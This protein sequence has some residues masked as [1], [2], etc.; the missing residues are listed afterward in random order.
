MP[1]TRDAHVTSK[2]NTMNHALIKISST[3]FGSVMY[4]FIGT[5][6]PTQCSYRNSWSSTDPSRA[7]KIVG[8]FTAIANVSQFFRPYPSIRRNR[9]GIRALKSYPRR[10]RM[11][12]E[13]RAIRGIGEKTALKVNRVIILLSV[14]EN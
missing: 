8:E 2:S 12:N 11:I 10:I 14:N 4:Y 6:K 1:L 5:A 7:M 13:A 3:R 9:T